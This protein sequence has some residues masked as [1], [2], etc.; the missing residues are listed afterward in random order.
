MPDDPLARLNRATLARLGREYMLAAQCN[1]RVGYA[2]LAMNHGP[3]AYKDVAIDNWMAVSPVY[4]RRMQRA[5]KLRGAS[6][7]ETILKGLQLECGFS[8]QYF[9][10]H[11]SMDAE[12]EG[13]F[14]LNSCAI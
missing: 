11:Y 9:D 2:A 4:T 14:W 13:R 8:H 7:V 6:D 1:S 10:V 5:M 12:N 3:A